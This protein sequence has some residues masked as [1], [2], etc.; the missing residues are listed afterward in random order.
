MEELVHRQESSFQFEYPIQKP[1]AK[2]VYAE[3]APA[4]SPQ[5]VARPQRGEIPSLITNADVLFRHSENELGFAL[6]RQ[7]LKIDSHHPEVLKQLAKFHTSQKKWKEAAAALEVVIQQDNSFSNLAQLAEK[8]YLMGEDSKALGIY[9]EALSIVMET[10]PLLFDIYKNVGNI[11]CRAGDFQSA[12]ECY[13]KAFT[14]NPNSDILHVNLGTL[15][16]QKGDYSSALNKFRGALEINPRNDKAWV[17][18]AMVHEKMG[19][20][21]LARANMENAIDIA[22][23]NR[24][25]VHILSAWALRDQKFETAIEALQNYLGEVSE[26]E[27]MSLALIH[28]FCL[29]EQYSLARFE[30]ERVLLWNP[31]QADVLAL[32][33]KIP[34]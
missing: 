23:G 34:G 29:T 11:H 19:D 25:A 13:C 3:K 22:P 6:V 17:G 10:S 4:V 8:Y 27:E 24:T 30:I 21:A 7:A 12:E 2:E 5:Q 9:E 33:E 20:F 14:L 15:E 1:F 26:D 18:L 32:L 28:L 16:I 31:H